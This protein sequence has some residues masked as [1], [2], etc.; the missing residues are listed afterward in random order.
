MHKAG[1]KPLVE[2]IVEKFVRL[3]KEMENYSYLCKA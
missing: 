2:K 1:I 3:W